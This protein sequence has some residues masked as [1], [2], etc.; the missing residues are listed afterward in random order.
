MTLT[1]L[2]L[3]CL[4]AATAGGLARLYRDVALAAAAESR[5]VAA[6]TRYALSGGGR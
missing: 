6:S 3:V 2:S 5:S 4:C 1:A